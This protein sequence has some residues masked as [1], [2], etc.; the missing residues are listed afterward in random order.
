MTAIPSKLH[1]PRGS[2]YNAKGLLR[3]YF[4]KVTDLTIDST[5]PLLT[6][7]NELNNS[8]SVAPRLLSNNVFHC[9]TRLT[10]PVDV[11]ENKH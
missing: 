6:V 3:D 9:S 4:P 1:W 8:P 2:N 11:D 5:E 7:E 10:N